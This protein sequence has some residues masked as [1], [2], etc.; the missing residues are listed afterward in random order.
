MAESTVK[1]LLLKG[2]DLS[3]NDVEHLSALL[4]KLKLLELKTLAKELS[5]CL[6]GSFQKDDII[7]RIMGMTRIGDMK[8]P[9]LTQSEE[10]TGIS[11]LTEGIKRV[12][13]DLLPFDSVT[14]W[15]KKLSGVLKE[16]TL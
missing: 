4:R 3:D 8:D 2:K 12:L 11:Y 10:A 7:D 13:R 15:D 9:T 1:A 14:Q 16:F 6:T 5:I